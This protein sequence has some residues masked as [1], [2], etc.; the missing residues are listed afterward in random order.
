MLP[1]LYHHHCHFI[2]V[3]PFSLSTTSTFFYHYYY[4]HIIIVTYAITTIP[5]LHCITV[6][7]LLLC[8]HHDIITAVTSSLSP[9]VLFHHH[10]YTNLLHHT[11]HSPTPSTHIHFFYPPF[12][13]H[14]HSLPLILFPSHPQFTAFHS[15][16]YPLSSANC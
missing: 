4:Y 11:S 16:P 6:A 9:P 3:C 10:H 2:Y 15:P 14:L 7:L 5:S 13:P 8:P 1:S 12:P